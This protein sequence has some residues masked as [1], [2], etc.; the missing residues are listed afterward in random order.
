[1]KNVIYY[2]QL[3]YFNVSVSIKD[4]KMED[5]ELN[6]TIITDHNTA[7]TYGRDYFTLIAD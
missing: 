2:L 3:A 4:W 7:L 6:V 1:V 5:C